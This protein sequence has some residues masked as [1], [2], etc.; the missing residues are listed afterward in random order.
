MGAEMRPKRDTAARAPVSAMTT[1]RAHRPPTRAYAR[2]REGPGAVG[3]LTPLRLLSGL[4]PCGGGDPPPRDESDEP[5]ESRDGPDPA[6]LQEGRCGADGRVQPGEC[7]AG[8]HQPEQRD[9]TRLDLSGQPS[10]A[11]VGPEGE[12]AVHLV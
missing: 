6:D 1:R 5:H 11:L 7:H 9:A 4:D 2:R 3:S 10:D 8:G 12:P